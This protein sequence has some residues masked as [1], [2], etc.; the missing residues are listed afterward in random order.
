MKRSMI[1]I[2]VIGIM[3][4]S[5][6][7]P[8]FASVGGDLSD[9]MI[10]VENDEEVLFILENV[11]MEIDN[12]ESSGIYPNWGS[13]DKG[14]TNFGTHGYIA[15]RGAHIV[16]NANGNIMSFLTSKRLSAIVKGS[17]LPDKDETTDL[18]AGHFYGPDGK[19][20]LGGD[21]TAYWNF[22]RHYK[23]AVTLFKKGSTNDALI[24]LGRALHYINDIAMPHHAMNKVAKL[25]RHTQF[26]DYVEE[27]FINY[28][29]GS[30]S[31]S[32]LKS[33]TTK[34]T[35]SI[36]DSTAVLARNNYENANSTNTTKMNTAAKNMMKRAQTDAAGV[37][38][39]FFKEVGKIK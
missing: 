33:Y 21:M 12:E 37:I 25:S 18:F 30:V 20:Y 17:V 8:S 31:L 26:E 32:T 7:M 5:S 16:K 10:T 38:Y 27:R 23:E 2:F 11:L 29:L 1:C 22:N 9:P 6:V 3:T 34:S 4:I 15:S 35:K 13:G 28:A 36:A 19:N 39:K 24:K 14:E